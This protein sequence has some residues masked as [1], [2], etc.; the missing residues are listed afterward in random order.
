MRRTKVIRALAV[1]V[2]GV[3][4]AAY[5]VALLGLTWLFC[6]V[7]GPGCDH[8]WMPPTIATAVYLAIIAPMI[9]V[10]RRSLRG[11]GDLR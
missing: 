2:S 6:Y 4:T 7:T 9:L 8:G 10:V 11:G 3:L 5:I 1:F